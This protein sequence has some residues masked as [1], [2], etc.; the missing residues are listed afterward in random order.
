MIT[1]AELVALAALIARAPAAPPRSLRR[2]VRRPHRRRP[3]GRCSPP[4][5]HQA[6]TWRTAATRCRG[7]A[8]G[9]TLTPSTR[10]SQPGPYGQPRVPVCA[11]CVCAPTRLPVTLLPRTVAGRCR[12]RPG[13][14]RQLSCWAHE[15][16]LHP[17]MEMTFRK[18]HVPIRDPIMWKKEENLRVR[19]FLTVHVK[20]RLAGFI[21]ILPPLPSRE[22]EIQDFTTCQHTVGP[23]SHV[24]GFQKISLY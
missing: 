11:A 14:A 12:G 7:S 6:A 3:A 24:I 2:R 10:R 20:M 18:R 19:L 4:G 1:L 16:Y 5:G 22:N 21:F 8:R 9:S 17:K 13:C 23:K 15:M